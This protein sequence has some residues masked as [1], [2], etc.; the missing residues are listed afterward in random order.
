MSAQS[1]YWLGDPTLLDHALALFALLLMVAVPLGL[2]VA[3]LYFVQWLLCG[4]PS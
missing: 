3:L 4:R 2:I 1:F